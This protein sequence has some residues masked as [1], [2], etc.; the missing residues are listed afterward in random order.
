MKRRPARP[1]VKKKEETKLLGPSPEMLDA[2]RVARIRELEAAL[3]ERDRVIGR[4]AESFATTSY[5]QSLLHAA[6]RTVI[7]QDKTRY[8]PGEASA[9][10]APVP[11]WGSIYLTPKQV[12]LGALR[13]I[14]VEHP[15]ARAATMS[16]EFKKPDGTAE[17]KQWAWAGKAE[18]QD[19][20]AL[21]Q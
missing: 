16:F 19:G 15:E 17:T 12:A 13:A 20:V 10:G 2:V 8:E 9:D 11:A 6:L 4:M 3:A 18:W 21:A 5:R 7:A 14:G 1:A